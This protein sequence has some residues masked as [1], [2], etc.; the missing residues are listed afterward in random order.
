MFTRF[1]LHW[2][3]LSSFPYRTSP[4]LV[5]SIWVRQT[6][7]SL[8]KLT[9]HAFKL[10]ASQWLVS[11]LELHYSNESLLHILRVVNRFGYS[12]LEVPMQ[13]LFVVVFFSNFNREFARNTRV[14]KRMVLS[15]LIVREG[16]IQVDLNFK[17]KFWSSNIWSQNSL[18]YTLLPRRIP[19][20]WN[21]NIGLIFK[22][23]LLSKEGSCWQTIR[24]NWP[25]FDVITLLSN[26]VM[27]SSQRR[28]LRLNCFNELQLVVTCDNLSA[29]NMVFEKTSQ[30]VFSNTR[31]VD[32]NRPLEATFV[33]YIWMCLENASSMCKW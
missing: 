17:R 5:N 23:M 29:L 18:L 27:A 28:R 2:T 7:L 9:R 19:D 32:L 8:A 12:T 24:I 15:I 22:I 33:N 14:V 11:K 26:H 21:W 30:V 4:K 31:K 16:K 13:S 1:S 10:P 3:W 25:S 20:Q 6:W